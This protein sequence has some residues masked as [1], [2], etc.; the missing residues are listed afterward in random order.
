LEASQ[1]FSFYRLWLLAP[2]PTPTLEGQACVFI[3]PE[4]GWPSYTPGHRVPILLLLTTRMGYGGTILIPRSPHGHILHYYTLN[5]KVTLSSETSVSYYTLKMEAAW[6]SETS[7]SYYITT[8]WRQ[9][10]PSKRCV[11]YH[12]TT[13]WR[14]KQHGPP[15]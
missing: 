1:Q 5:M 12:I 3:S 13:A 6:S 4:A 8:P 14:W 2:R 11:S 9:L 10:G 7:V 15:K